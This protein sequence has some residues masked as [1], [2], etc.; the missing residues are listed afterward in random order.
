MCMGCRAKTAEIA[1]G[2]IAASVVG[3]SAYGWISEHRSRLLLQQTVT[4][5]PAPARFVF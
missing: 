2:G 1:I 3:I 4:T 5:P